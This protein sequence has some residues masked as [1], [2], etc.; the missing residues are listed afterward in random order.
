MEVKDVGFV[1]T[2]E[3]VRYI[4]VNAGLKDINFQRVH[5]YKISASGLSQKKATM[6]QLVSNQERLRRWGIKE[7]RD[8]NTL[9]LARSMY[10]GNKAAISVCLA[11]IE[12]I[13][14]YLKESRLDV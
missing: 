12:T 6:A 14:H 11:H 3:V 10:K 9:V 2:S 4:E 7:G 13:E 5:A 1:Q 8:Q